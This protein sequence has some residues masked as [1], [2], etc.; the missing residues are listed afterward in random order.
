[1][2]LL[3]FSV[4]HT[5][6]KLFPLIFRSRDFNSLLHSIICAILLCNFCP[7]LLLLFVLLY[8]VLHMRINLFIKKKSNLLMIYVRTLDAD[9]THDSIFVLRTLASIIS[10]R[11]I[12]QHIWFLF[13]WVICLSALSLSCLRLETIGKLFHIWWNN[14]ARWCEICISRKMFTFLEDDNPIT[15]LRKEYFQFIYTLCQCFSLF[16]YHFLSSILWLL[17]SRK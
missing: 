6:A 9:V 7:T 4:C 15:V 10:L 12:A 14:D 8:L 16:Y 13:H 11:I 5:H 2:P 1:M 17:N 3:R